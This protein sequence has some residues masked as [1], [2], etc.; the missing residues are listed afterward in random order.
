MVAE[1]FLKPSSQGDRM[2]VAMAQPEMHTTRSGLDV[3]VRANGSVSWTVRAVREASYE[4]RMCDNVLEPARADLANAGAA[5]RPRRRFV[6]VDENVHRLYGERIHRYFAVHGIDIGLEILHVT[7]ERKTFGLV[8]QIARSIDAFGIARRCEPIIAFGGGILLDIV[9]LAADLYRRGTPFVRVPT[10]LVGLVDA[11][12]GVKTGINFNDH[13]NRLG[14]YSSAALTLLDR[15]FLRSLPLRHVS[16]GLAEV[17]KISLVKDARLFELLEKDGPVLL[18]E[19][20]Q[21][22]SRVR[23]AGSEVIRRAI[24]GMLEE[25]QPNLWEARL[26]RLPDYGHT[27]SPTIEMRAL[28]SLLHGEAVN[29]D[30]ALTTVLASSRG[31]VSRRE[32]DRVLAVMTTLGLPCWHPVITPELLAAALAD[33][34][35]HRDG[36]QRLPLPVGIGNARFVNDV[37]AAEIAVAVKQLWALCSRWDPADA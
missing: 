9:G 26:E 19:K 1:R 34:V 2:R 23:A 22:D 37:S 27:F 36:Q 20:F 17:L 13:K 25:L 10:T 33:T 32:R 6:V 24:H 31:M 12:I 4:V 29:L 21:G 8:A 11:G 16:N 3:Q 30:M 35:R 14:T 5:H 18:T 28:P 7:E 15:S